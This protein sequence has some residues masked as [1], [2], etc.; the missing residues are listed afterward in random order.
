MTLP[1]K[2][3]FLDLNHKWNLIA[4]FWF[5][6]PFIALLL[7]ILRSPIQINNYLIFKNVFWHTIQEQ[8]LY[9]FY[10][11]EYSDKNHYG[12]LFSLLFAP[13]AILPD[14]IGVVLWGMFNI[15][16][17]FYAIH[18]L[19]ISSWGKN[20]I[21]LLSLIET[22]TS[23]QN[24]QSNPLICSLI[25]LTY[26]SIKNNKLSVA[27]FIIVA[28]TFIKLYGIVGLPFIFLS[29]DYKK[30][31]GYLFLWTF[32][33]FCLPMFISSF[34]FIVQT[35]KD[36][37]FCLI[38]KNSENLLASVN[39]GMQDISVMGFFKRITGNYKLQ[40]FYFL[41]PAATLMLMPLY[42]FSK[43]NNLKYQLTYLA[44]ILI[45]VVIFSSS[46]ESPTYVIAVVGFAIWYVLYAPKPPLWLYLLLVLTL[47][48]TVF[49]PTNLFPRY[50]REAYVL[51]YS[52]KTL[53][54]FIAWLL[55]SFNLLFNNFTKVTVYEKE[56]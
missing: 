2:Y 41:I 56:A 35:Y 28:G 42:R 22:L 50:L 3:R 38:E 10:P 39:G 14:Y 7:E 48:L 45:G 30:I 1:I 20:I 27:A 32:I 53:P 8:N 5:L 40:N 46:A 15:A 44:Q 25:V 24:L 49:T 47:L 16:I 4:I 51:K 21:L 55:I 54:C 11:N 17:L 9:N 6:V 26:V 36:W 37:Y 13:F 33:L 31:L 34:D 52:L 18:K 23:I 29:K 43:L 19:P 12:P